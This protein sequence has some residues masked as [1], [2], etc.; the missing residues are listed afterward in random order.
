MLYIEICLL[1]A[2]AWK[3]DP[4]HVISYLRIST[5]FFP[6]LHNPN[7]EMERLENI[8]SWEEVQQ[9]LQL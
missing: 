9:I 7:L 3:Y 6:Y 1:E 4:H 5:K 8:N 2:K